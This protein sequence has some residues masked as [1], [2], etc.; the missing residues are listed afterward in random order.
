MGDLLVAEE[1]GLGGGVE[2]LRVVHGHLGGGLAEVALDHVQWHARVQQGGAL[3]VP[4]S[5]G[6]LEVD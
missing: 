6:A 4:E 1:L 2:G 3:R 5:V